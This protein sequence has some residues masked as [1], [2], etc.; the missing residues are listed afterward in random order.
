MKNTLPSK[1]STKHSKSLE[2]KALK[3]AQ[4]SGRDLYLLSM[5]GDE[6]LTISGVSRVSRDDTGRLIGYQRSEVRK[7]VREIAD[8]LQSSEMILAHPLILSFNSSVHFTSSRGQKTSDGIAT[9]GMLSITL[10]KSG[11]AKP[12]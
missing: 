8:Y 11:E 6:L 7:H 12:A 1:K 10:T 9:A 3:I 2:R 5:T 4:P